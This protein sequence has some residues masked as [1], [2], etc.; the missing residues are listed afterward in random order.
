MVDKDA[1]EMHIFMPSNKENELIS[2][3]KRKIF[4]VDDRVVTTVGWKEP[5]SVP[6][7]FEEQFYNNH[8][9][10]FKVLCIAE[11]LEGT[12]AGK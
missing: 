2:F 5:H 3:N 6:I 11:P 4:I 9:E 7:V 1:I 12:T 10:P 8:L